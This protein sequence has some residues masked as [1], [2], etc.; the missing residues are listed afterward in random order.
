MVIARYFAETL[1]VAK[2]SETEREALLLF[3]RKPEIVGSLER[4]LDAKRIKATKGNNVEEGVGE[5]RA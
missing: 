1:N 2:E 5:Q 4:V 3:T